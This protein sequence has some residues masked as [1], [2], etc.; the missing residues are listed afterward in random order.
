MFVSQLSSGQISSE[1][2]RIDMP[3]YIKHNSC[4]SASGSSNALR[5]LLNIEQYE[6]MR[7]PQMDAG[8]KVNNIL[9]QT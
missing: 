5:L 1:C 9:Y 2:I 8:V 6:I 7:G 4:F 3:I